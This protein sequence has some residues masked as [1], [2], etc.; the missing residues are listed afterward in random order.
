MLRTPCYVIGDAHL[1]IASKDAE[2]ALIAF[3]RALPARARSLVIMGDLFDFWFGWTD[4]KST[5]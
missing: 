1:G 2:R 3:L 4:R 5:L